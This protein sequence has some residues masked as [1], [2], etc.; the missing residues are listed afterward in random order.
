[1]K[2]GEGGLGEM[3]DVKELETSN[4]VQKQD[5]SFLHK[6]TKS[7]LS[8]IHIKLEMPAGSAK[9]PSRTDRKRRTL[10]LSEMP[11]S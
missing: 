10:E 5:A 6:A 4:G 1:V 7:T 9:M 8:E 11:V 3:S 2:I